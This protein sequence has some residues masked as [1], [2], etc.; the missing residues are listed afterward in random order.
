MD[1]TVYFPE[2]VATPPLASAIAEI[3]SANRKALRNFFKAMSFPDIPSR[4]LAEHHRE[5]D[6]ECAPLGG[7]THDMDVIEA[8]L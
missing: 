5:L 4:N 3:A 2:A 6:L 7:R 1:V 8:P